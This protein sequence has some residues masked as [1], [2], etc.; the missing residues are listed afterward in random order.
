MKTK[1]KLV[2]ALAIVLIGSLT[3]AP[4]FAGGGFDEYGYNWKARTFVG[5]YESYYMERYGVYDHAT[6][7]AACGIY[8]HDKLVVKWSMA[9]QMAE[10]GPNGIREDGDE[11]PWTSDA[12]CINEWNGAVGRQWG[13]GIVEGSGEVEH[14]KIIWVGPELEDSPYW[15]EGGYAIWGEFEVILDFYCGPAVEGIEW[16][17]LATPNGLGGP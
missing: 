6:A 5:T 7:E 16:Y 11:L 1:M 12:W 4:A 14:V 9:W 3:I 17:A 13:G 15:R 8:A 10:W 2:M